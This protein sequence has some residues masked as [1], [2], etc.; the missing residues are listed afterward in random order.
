MLASDAA[1]GAFSLAYGHGFEGLS[2]TRT[3]DGREALAQY[4]HFT[5]PYFERGSL[6]LAAVRTQTVFIERGPKH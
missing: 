6:T 4:I 1:V 2:I 5:E 3:S